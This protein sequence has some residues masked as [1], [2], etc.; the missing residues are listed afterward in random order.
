[1]TTLINTTRGVI[2]VVDRPLKLNGV[3][4]IVTETDKD[5]NIISEVY[6]TIIAS[7]F[8]VGKKLEFSIDKDNTYASHIGWDKY[9][10][11]QCGKPYE[12]TETETSILIKL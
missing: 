7:T 6:K 12:Y 11:E 10:K 5:G 1:M 9:V 3:P 2:A 4:Y 8:G